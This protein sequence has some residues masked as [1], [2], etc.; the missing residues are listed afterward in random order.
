MSLSLPV[1]LTGARGFLG[2]YVLKGLAQKGLP[3]CVVGKNEVTFQNGGNCNFIKMDLKQNIPS[4]INGPEHFSSVVHLASYVP[5]FAS[6]KGANEQDA[7][8]EGVYLSTQRLL[9]SLVGKTEHLIYASSIAVYGN[10]S[11]LIDESNACQPAD[12]YGLYKFFGEELCRLFAKQLGIQLTILRFTQLYGTGEPH[13]IFLKRVFL[14]NARKGQPIRLIRGG[15]DER[16]MLWIEDAAEAVL[17]AVEHQVE[18]T[19]NISTGTGTTI[20]NIAELICKNTSSTSELI[21]D[22]DGSPA[23]S[24]IYSIERAR[25]ELGFSPVVSIEDG[26]SRLCQ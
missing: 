5:S 24:Q 26:L 23:V 21:I 13:G 14:E 7:I 2:T 19:F 18:G 16:D 4:D 10:A 3:V 22:D 6:S 25:R 17:A 1:L 11:G 15:R 12:Y 8:M 20:R 9:K